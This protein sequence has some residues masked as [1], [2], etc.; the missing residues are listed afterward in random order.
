VPTHKSSLGIIED[1]KL[2]W[3]V[4]PSVTETELNTTAGLHD[5]TMPQTTRELDNVRKFLGVK[6]DDER[7]G[8]NGVND[9]SV[10]GV[11]TEML[12]VL[13]KN[14]VRTA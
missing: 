5:R 1:D 2:D 14:L 7:R 6:A 3:L 12:T 11:G 8:A 4:D 10:V 9:V 13:K